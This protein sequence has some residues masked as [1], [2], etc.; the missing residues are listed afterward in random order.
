M[1]PNHYRL[2]V[3][4]ELGPRYASA[5]EEMTVTT[6]DGVTEIAGEIIDSAH[7]HGL[8][9]RVSSLGLEVHSLIPLD[10]TEAASDTPAA[11]KPERP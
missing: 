6:H 1:P 7:L 8:L 10:A 2:V 3:K 11:T 5:F 4:G 9:E